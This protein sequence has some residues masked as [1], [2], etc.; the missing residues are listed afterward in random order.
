M[1]EAGLRGEVGGKNQVVGV[2]VGGRL[3]P[4]WDS[5]WRDW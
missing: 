2:A 1:E 4:G 5:C 3:G